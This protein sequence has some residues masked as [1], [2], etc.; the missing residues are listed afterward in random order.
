M[1]NHRIE[2]EQ[3]RKGA[4]NVVLP[5]LAWRGMDIA[6]ESWPS[7][8]EAMEY[9]QPAARNVPACGRWV[10]Q[11]VERSGNCQ[12]ESSI[13]TLQGRKSGNR[14]RQLTTVRLISISFCTNSTQQLV[15]GNARLVQ[16]PREHHARVRGRGCRPPIEQGWEKR[17]RKGPRKKSRE[18]WQ[19]FSNHTCI[20]KEGF[21]RA[22]QFSAYLLKAISRAMVANGCQVD[23]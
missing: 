10:V 18:F 21:N 20:M 7:K 15:Q 16:H 17:R 11:G 13:V 8:Q 14:L 19:S 12:G 9:A 2:Q 1:V 3:D 23:S 4:G 6:N 5:K 22:L